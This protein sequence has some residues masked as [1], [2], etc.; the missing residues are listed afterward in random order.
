MMGKLTEPMKR[1]I[2]DYDAGAVGTTHEDGTPAV[3]PRAAFVVIDDGCIAFGNIRSPGTVANIRSRPDE[4]PPFRV[5]RHLPSYGSTTS[6]PSSR[7]RCTSERNHSVQ[8]GAGSGR[9]CARSNRM[10]SATPGHP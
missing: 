3:S 5:S 6:E 4:G 10:Q 8:S 7:K 1:L 9:R 2:A